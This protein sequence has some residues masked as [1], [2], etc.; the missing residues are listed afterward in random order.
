MN[1]RKHVREALKA[2]RAERMAWWICVEEGRTGLN[3]YTITRRTKGVV[4]AGRRVQKYKNMLE[5][6]G[7]RW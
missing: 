7:G 4:M 6:M 2:A 1:T 5:R 3:G